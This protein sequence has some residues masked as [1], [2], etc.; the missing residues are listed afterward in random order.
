[1]H[2]RGNPCSQPIQTALRNETRLEESGGPGG[3]E[4]LLAGL[5]VDAVGEGELE[6]LDENL[7]HVWAADV[8]GLLDLNN[9]EDLQCIRHGARLLRMWRHT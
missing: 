2:N 6:A 4:D 8:V 3:R 9:L 1:M 7:L 5:L